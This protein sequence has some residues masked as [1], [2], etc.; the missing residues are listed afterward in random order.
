[1]KSMILRLVLMP[2]GLFNKIIQISNDGSRDLV[3]KLRF[4][5]VKIDQ[6]VCIDGKTKMEKNIHILAKVLINNSFI[7]SFTYIGKNTVVQNATI[8]K[9]CSIANDVCI[10]LGKHPIDNFSTATIFYRKK[11]TLNI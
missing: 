2:F 11:N 5:G 10:G 4:R 7:D 1:M 3:N 9:F 6:G 8:G